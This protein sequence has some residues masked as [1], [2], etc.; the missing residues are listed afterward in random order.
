[1]TDETAVFGVRLSAGRRSAGLSQEELAERS[2]LSVRAIGNLERGRTRWPYPDSVVRLADALRLRGHE[3]TQF[4]AAAGRRL[5]QAATD[6]VNPERVPSGQL[7]GVGSHPCVPRQLPA[8]VRHFVGRVR[9]Q[10]VL[11]ALLDEAGTGT[12]AVVIS[13]IGGTAGVGKTALALQWAHQIADRFPDGQLYVNLRGYDIDTPLSAAD[14]LA[15]FLRAL[16]VDGRNIPPDE[17][18]R[19]AAYR[20]LL[21][22][23]RMLIVVDNAHRPEQVRPLLPGTA[24]CAVLVTSRDTLAGLVAR[25]GAVRLELDVLPLNAS[26]G[27]LRELIGTR[28]DDDPAA[29]AT[30]AAC[31]CRLPLALRVAA[32]LAVARPAVPLAVLVAELTD[33]QHRLDALDAVGDEG[34]AVRA[35]FSWSYRHLDAE[36]ARAFR[37][38]ALHPGTDFD[39]YAIAAL[40]D[41][42]ASQAARLLYR[43]TRAHLIHHTDTDRYGMHDL[44][45]GYARERAAAQDGPP[46][47]DAALTRLFDRYLYTAAAAMDTLFPAEASRRPCLAPFPGELAPVADP[48]AAQAWLDAERANLIAAAAHAADHGLPHAIGLSAT[49]ERYLT[50]G[51]RLSE[52]IALHS[53]ALHSARR[54]GDR[55]AEATALSHLGFLEWESGRSRKAADHQR[56]A[57]QLFHGTTDRTGLCRALHRLALAEHHLGNLD[58]AAAHAEQVLALCRQAGDRLGQARARQSLAI[59]RRSQGAFTQATDLFHEVL[60][61]LDE[62]G[63]R[64]TRSVPLQQLGAIDLRFGR[65][66]SAEDRLTQAM[67]LCHEAGNRSGHA[68]ALSLLGLVHLRHGRDQRAAEYQQRAL[69]LFRE[70]ADRH[71]EAEVLTRLAL[72][73]RSAGHTHQALE[74]L[75]HALD[76]AGT[77][78][79]RLVQTTVLNTFGET[80]LST[81]QARHATARLTAALTLAGRS[82]DRDEQARAHQAL[83]CAHAVLGDRD[84]AHSHLR[85]ALTLYT[86]LGVPE[87]GRIRCPASGNRDALAV[88]QPPGAPLR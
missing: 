1:M 8:P 13:A 57:L 14:A 71:G 2:G 73:D 41:T 22:H 3:R 43:L 63:D 17:E 79:A 62:L 86:T 27:L 69:A 52:A 31:C 80:L 18:A 56:Q 53:H 16:G 77:L 32:E 15:G 35:A 42:D 46:Q 49:V 11:N 20:S 10:Q 34:T 30:L 58:A 66:A 36:A 33:L 74:H 54:L 50:F 9:E 59:T 67:Q 40:L 23:R 81:G 88:R 6:P 78:D 45:R 28:V 68:E 5:S 39:R 47:C 55:A 7:S 72:A 26:V 60:A 82:G 4:I 64:R 12:G 70:I 48:P 29:C 21:A 65:L 61:L 87:A 38:T 84:Q 76:L 51:Y 85:E 75:E 83:A 37:L 24:G 44:L 25:D 19:A